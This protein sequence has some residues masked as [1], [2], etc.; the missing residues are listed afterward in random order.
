MNLFFRLFLMSVLARFRP[1][2]SI[3]QSCET[4][5]R[6]WPTDLDIQRH[7]NNGQY[8]SILDLARIDIIS[9][10]G[11]AKKLAH[12][13]WYPV[14][15]AETIRFKKSI[16]LFDKFKVITKVL[17]WDEKAFI[18]KQTFIRKDLPIAEA[19][20]RIR[21]LKKSGGLV[22]PNEVLEIAEI[23]STSPQIEE[24][25]QHWNQNQA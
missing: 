22:S 23:G 11:L 19:V 18:L 9:R 16:L 1:S 8:L 15:V 4:N 17:G 12:R 3:L 20:I 13:G 25:I 21:F 14:V 5:F 6:C 7:M 24:W 10:A 2:L